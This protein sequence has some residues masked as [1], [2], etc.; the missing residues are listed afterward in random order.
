ML[1]AAGD[2]SVMVMADG[3]LSLAARV[4]QV[5]ASMRLRRSSIVQRSLLPDLVRVAEEVT[6]GD[7]E[8]PT[9]GAQIPVAAVAPQVRIPEIV[10]RGTLASQVISGSQGFATRAVQSTAESFI[11]SD[12]AALAVVGARL[13]RTRITGSIVAGARAPL[14]VNIELLRPFTIGPSRR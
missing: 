4:E 2:N 1:D 6:E 5:A 3:T 12:S 13:Q 8:P 7:I 11:G 10:P 9:R 14:S